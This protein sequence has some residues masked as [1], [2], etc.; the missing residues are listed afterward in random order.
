MKL[1]KRTPM[2]NEEDIEEESWAD[3]NRIDPITNP[4]SD[5]GALRLSAGILEAT[6]NDYVNALKTI[7]KLDN[8]AKHIYKKIRRYDVWDY[9]RKEAESLLKKDF[10]KLNH[11]QSEAVVIAKLLRRPTEPTKEEIE[12]YNAYLE[13]LQ[14]KDECEAFY[15]SKRYSI[16]TLGKGL[17]GYEVIKAIKEKVGY[18]LK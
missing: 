9:Y 8:Q 15:L 6:H 12:I 4:L 16:L 11:K 18:E 3:G 7:M 17:K 5:E 1:R 10:A 13:A 14:T 2:Y